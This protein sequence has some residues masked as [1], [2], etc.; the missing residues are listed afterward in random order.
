MKTVVCVHLAYTAGTANIDRSASVIIRD[1]NSEWQEVIG[2]E[3]ELLER[4]EPDED[5]A[6]FEAEIDGDGE[7]AIGERVPPPRSE[8]H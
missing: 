1:L 8:L 3:P 2:P 4:I 7:L 6:Y 5:L